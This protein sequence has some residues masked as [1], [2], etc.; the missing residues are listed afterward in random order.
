VN[1]EIRIL[2]YFYVS[3]IWSLKKCK[4]NK[5]ADPTLKE[6]VNAVPKTKNNTKTNKQKQQQKEQVAGQS[7]SLLQE[8]G[9]LLL[10][11]FPFRSC[12]AVGAAEIVSVFL[13]YLTVSPRPEH[14]AILS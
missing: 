3:S 11:L 10:F 2:Y 4:Q 9:A 14:F 1:T 13:R 5:K 6:L 8:A 7:S 12:K